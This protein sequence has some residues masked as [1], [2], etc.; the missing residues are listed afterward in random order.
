MKNLDEINLLIAA[1]E[2]ELADLESSRSKLLSRAAE[3]QR[4]KA[5]FHQSI[6]PR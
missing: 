3:L 5:T 2:A 6:L 4:E 1:T